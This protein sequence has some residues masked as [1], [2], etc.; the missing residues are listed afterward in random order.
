MNTDRSCCGDCGVPEGELHL[1]ECDME[2]CSDC[3]GQFMTCDCPPVGRRFPYIEYP[4]FCA[5][6]GKPWPG[7]FMVPDAE[8]EK[9]IQPNMRDKVICRDCY[10]YIKNLTDSINEDERAIA[11]EEL[12]ANR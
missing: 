4:I 2:V 9:Y 5:K 11:R 6:C 7:F 3:G 1:P 12:D 8:W 10:D